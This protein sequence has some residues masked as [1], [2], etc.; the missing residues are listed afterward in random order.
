[1]SLPAHEW[2]SSMTSLILWLC[3]NLPPVQASVDAGAVLS[4]HLA[5]RTLRAALSGGLWTGPR[6]RGRLPG[7][8]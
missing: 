4:P 5:P 2:G 6:H 8:L 7:A 1:M 3:V